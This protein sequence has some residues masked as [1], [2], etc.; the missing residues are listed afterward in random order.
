MRS[1]RTSQGLAVAACV[2]LAGC[3]S[4]GPPP[5]APLAP[6]AAGAARTFDPA[7]PPPGLAPAVARGDA[8]IG[9]LQRRLGARL[10]AALREGGPAAAVTVCRD[11]A[12]RLTAAV[13]EEQGVS[14]GRTSDRLRNPRNA[15][16]GWA[17]E[18]VEASAG[19]A[20][21]DV[22]PAAVELGDRVGLL[23]PIVVAQPC[24]RCHG[25]RE[26]LPAEVAERLAREYPEDRAVGYGAGDHRG[27]FWVEVPR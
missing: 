25:E 8:A 23:R 9:E 19:R 5:R 20:A 15:P 22:R 1:S 3:S 4:D 24:T 10:A 17:R 16:P 13:G 27:F 26:Q 18:L 6:A 12:P 2:V 14:I 7:T 11:D 21:S